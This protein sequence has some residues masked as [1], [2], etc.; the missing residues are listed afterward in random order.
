MPLLIH[1]GPGAS[2]MKALI[3]GFLQGVAGAI[4][5]LMPVRH[6]GS[7]AAS[8]KTRSSRNRLAGRPRASGRKNKTRKARS[9]KRS[10]KRSKKGLGPADVV[11][12]VVPVVK[13]VA[14]YSC[15]ACGLQA[16][17]GLMAE[18]LLGSPA[19]Q[20]GSV[21]PE[22]TT[23]HRGEEE[24]ADAQRD[25]DS[26][27]SLRNLLQMLIPP[28]A[29]GRRHEQKTVNPLTHLVQAPPP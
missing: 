22:P 26:R 10:G 11:A 29:F 2:G 18:H 8:R 15:P 9:G 12:G 28:R 6:S 3:S 25:E 27:E 4:S 1:D 23:D 19:H 14:I 24:P 17:E 21:Q 5:G 20:H 16:P 13:T 7:R